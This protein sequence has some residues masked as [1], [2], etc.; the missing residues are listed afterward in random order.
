[1]T[2]EGYALLYY[3]GLLH[4]DYSIFR[5][6]SFKPINNL[7]IFSLHYVYIPRINQALQE[8]IQ[9]WNH[10]GMRIE[11]GQNPHQLFTSG[12]LQLQNAGNTALDFLK[13]SL[14]LMGLR[15]QEILWMVMSRG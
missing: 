6:Q 11:R 2:L 13:K 7:H 9:S 1:M 4:V 14:I 5:A 10:H 8:F 15:I 12:S 3:F